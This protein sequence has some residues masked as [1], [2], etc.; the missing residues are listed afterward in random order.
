VSVEGKAGPDLYEGPPLSH[1]MRA[2]GLPVGMMLVGKDYD[3]STIY[4]AAAAFE[5]VGDWKTF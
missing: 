2:A 1:V 4:A 5:G 3:E